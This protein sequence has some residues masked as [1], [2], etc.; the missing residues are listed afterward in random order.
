M[1]HRVR[2]K[3]D[4]AFNLSLFFLSMKI[5]HAMALS[6]SRLTIYLSLFCAFIYLL[7]IHLSISLLT[8][9]LSLS[10]AFIYLS[11]THLSFLLLSICLS[12]L[13]I[14]LSMYRYLFVHLYMKVLHPGVRE[15]ACDAGGGDQGR[16]ATV[17][18]QLPHHSSRGHLSI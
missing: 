3:A 14:Y 12:P 2:V 10:Y 6:N 4:D 15:E 5:L 17:N 1:H 18:P 11:L 16:R 9:F 13:F 7:L 8:I